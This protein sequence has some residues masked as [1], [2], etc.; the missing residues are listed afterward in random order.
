MIFF[1]H[2]N[3]SLSYKVVEFCENHLVYQT[4]H[5]FLIHNCILF[6]NLQLPRQKNRGGSVCCSLLHSQDWNSQSVRY[7]S[8][9]IL[10][11]CECIFSIHLWKETS[12]LSVFFLQPVIHQ[13]I[14]SIITDIA[15]RDTVDPALASRQ[16]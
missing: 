7:Y 9:I 2:Y 15:D 12:T 8:S 14:P 1:K 10:T 13:F 4:H 16:L 6:L 3:V 11:V 5:D